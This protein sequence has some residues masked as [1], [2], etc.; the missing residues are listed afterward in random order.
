[1]TRTFALDVAKQG[2]VANSIAPGCKSTYLTLL[3]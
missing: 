1:M 2:I 3:N